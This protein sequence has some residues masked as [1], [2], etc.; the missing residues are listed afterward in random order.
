MNLFGLGQKNTKF[1]FRST[2][3]TNKIRNENVILNEKFHILNVFEN[4]IFDVLK[5]IKKNNIL[6]NLFRKFET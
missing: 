4:L 2:T 3:I 6:S 5:N 1:L